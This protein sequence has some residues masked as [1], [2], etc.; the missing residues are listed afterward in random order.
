MF[1][2]KI[3]VQKFRK[4]WIIGKRF[5]WFLMKNED[6]IMFYFR[7][8]IITLLNA[9]WSTNCLFQ[10]VNNWGGACSSSKLLS[11]GMEEDEQL[12]LESSSHCD[13]NSRFKISTICHFLPSGDLR[14]CVKMCYKMSIKGLSWAIF[15]SMIVKSITVPIREW[16]IRTSVGLKSKRAN[17]SAG[18]TSN[19]AD[20]DA[21]L[22][23]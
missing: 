17:T 5:E 4:F 7:F 2:Q 9:K 13:G 8:L 15:W 14:L 10:G 21:T 3:V 1:A 18:W 6:A 23:K 22:N 19:S 12:G 20:T 16:N 11:L